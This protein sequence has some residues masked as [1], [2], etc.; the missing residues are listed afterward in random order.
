MDINKLTFISDNYEFLDC[1]EEYHNKHK[2]YEEDTI[3]IYS[4]INDEMVETRKQLKEFN[5][6]F[7]EYVDEYDQVYLLIEP[8]KN[9]ITKF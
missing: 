7:D 3:I 8:V 9:G 4:Y 5:I 6:T 1:N 2:N